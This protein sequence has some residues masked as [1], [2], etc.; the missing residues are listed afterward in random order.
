MAS[1]IKKVSEVGFKVLTCPPSSFV[2]VAGLMRL[3]DQGTLCKGKPGRGSSLLLSL[4]GDVGSRFVGFWLHAKQSRESASAR[5][6][7]ETD[8]H[9]F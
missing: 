1:W 9:S 6:L 5:T 8:M 7:G 4:V 3:T 2:R